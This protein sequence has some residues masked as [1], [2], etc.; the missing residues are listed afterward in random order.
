MGSCLLCQLPIVPAS[1]A[2]RLKPEDWRLKPED[3]RHPLFVYS[4]KMYPKKSKF[5]WLLFYVICQWNAPKHQYWAPKL[6]NP[7]RP[8]NKIFRTRGHF[9]EKLPLGIAS[10]IKN[11]PGAIQWS[12]G[13]NWPMAPVHFQAW[14]Q[15]KGVTSGTSFSDRFKKSIIAKQGYKPFEID[16]RLGV[17]WYDMKWYLYS[18]F[19][20]EGYKAL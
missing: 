19:W 20:P 5:R 16:H 3:W 11:W 6:R 2:S 9:V 10:L 14:T 8:G 15:L 1:H 7:T 13:A 12:M 18:A 17:I 4:V